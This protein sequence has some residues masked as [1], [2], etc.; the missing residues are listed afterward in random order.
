MNNLLNSFIEACGFNHG[1]G[2]LEST[3]RICAPSYGECGREYSA[4]ERISKKVA[5]VGAVALG[6]YLSKNGVDPLYPFI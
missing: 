2:G 1:F 3:A 4:T 6:L 5:T